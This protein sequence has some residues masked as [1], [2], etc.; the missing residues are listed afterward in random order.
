MPVLKTYVDDS[1][2]TGVYILANVGGSHPVTLQVTDLGATI[3]EKAGYNPPEVSVPTRV[4]WAMYDIGLLYTSNVINDIPSFEKGTDDVFQEMGLS[5][6][7]GSTERNQ[8][9]QLLGEYTGPNEESVQQLR[10][11][12][13]GSVPGSTLDPTRSSELQ[14]DFERL[15][16]LYQ[17]DLLLDKE[18][19]L[20]KSRALERNS[21]EGTSDITNDMLATTRQY[22]NEEQVANLT[23]FYASL[24]PEDSYGFLS[25]GIG[26]LEN[27][28][29][30]DTDI[31]VQVAATSHGSAENSDE[32]P[33]L[34]H[35]FTTNTAKQ[36]ERLK[37]H[38]V[39]HNYEI[40]REQ[41]GMV[42]VK[43]GA[44]PNA[45]SDDI[46]DSALHREIECCFE[47][48]QAVYKTEPKEIYS[49]FRWGMS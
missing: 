32:A 5:N 35:T 1:E 17:A 28:R 15:R 12:V 40:I 34:K 37:K 8:L 22:L 20:L 41:K 27:R 19:S 44:A 9:T 10:E 11:R 21:G 48:I 7:L 2:Q 6:Q 26:V 33:S 30:V 47:A 38:V 46:S 45:F 3:L 43:F 24:V 25:E 39:Q 18:Y 13:E 42:S 4:V 14:E 23:D 36:Q 29:E 49:G 31:F 16:E